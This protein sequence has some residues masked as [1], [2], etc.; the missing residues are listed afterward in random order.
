MSQTAPAAGAPLW[1]S[2]H[3]CGRRLYAMTTANRSETRMMCPHD[4]M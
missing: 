2:D 4:A 3:L 1:S